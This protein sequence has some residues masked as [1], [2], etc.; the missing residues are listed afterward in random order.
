MNID[1]I[2]KLFLQELSEKYPENEIKSFYYYSA[3]TVLGFSRIDIALRKDEEITNEKQSLF[4]DILK[5]IK[6]DIPIQYIL[7]KTEFY[8]LSFNVNENVLIPRPETEELVDWII[9]DNKKQDAAIIDIGT[10]SGCIAISLK[11][12]FLESIVYAVDIS[13]E[14]LNVAKI[15]ALLNNVIIDFSKLDIL[16]F[17]D[18]NSFSKFDIIVSNPPYVRD[19]EKKLM[20]NNVLNY[21][22][23]S[24]LFVSDNNPLIFYKAIAEFAL[25]YLNKNGFL[26]FEIN[27]NLFVE[28]TEM[29]INKGFYNVVV[30]ED[31]NKKHRML[32]CLINS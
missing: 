31:I 25:K 28:L 12:H 13:E 29:L 4:F 21:E 1:D 26:Y 15:N 30:K 2:R 6:L 18:N 19:S 24:A 20:K 10:G 16:N 7:G 14:A 17:P 22:P 32:R 8:G 11:K 27:E 9:K 23:H 3:H 5:K